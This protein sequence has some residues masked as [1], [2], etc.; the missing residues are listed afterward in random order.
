MTGSLEPN[1]SRPEGYGGKPDNLDPGFGESAGPSLPKRLVF[2]DF[3]RAT[4]QYD[5]VVGL[6]LVFIFATPRALFHDQPKP[7]SLV[8]L[9][10]PNGAGQV[11]IGTDLLDHIPESLRVS[12]AQQLV[13][14]RTGKQWRVTRVEPLRDETEQEI[15]GFIAYTNP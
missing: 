11:F 5:V 10:S 15:K 8:L 13:Q 7:A 2:W 6:I 1:H 14:K 4:W 9:T 12:K 3:A